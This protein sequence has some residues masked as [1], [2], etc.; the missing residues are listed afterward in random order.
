MVR[1]AFRSKQCSKHIAEQRVVVS[2]FRQVCEGGS[3]HVFSCDVSKQLMRVVAATA[4]S[5][6][7]IKTGTYNFVDGNGSSEDGDDESRRFKVESN[8]ACPLPIV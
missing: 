3:A 6:S 7:I 1:C 4:T 2:L 5:I 8:L